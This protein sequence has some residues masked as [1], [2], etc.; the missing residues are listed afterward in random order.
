MPRLICSINEC[1]TPA[2]H[3]NTLCGKHGGVN[4]SDRCKID[5]CNKYVV[6]DGACVKH[7]AKV[8]RCKHEGCTKQAQNNSL[9][10]KHGAERPTC[11]VE[12]CT[13]YIIKSGVCVKHGAK[14]PRCNVEGCNSNRQGGGVCVKHGGT[15]NDIS[16]KCTLC[17]LYRADRKE[18]PTKNEK[19]RLCMNC[20][21]YTFPNEKIPSRYKKKQHYLHDTLKEKYGED[22]FEYD[23]KIDGGC[24]RKI[25]DWFCDRGTHSVLIECDENSH[26]YQSDICENKRMMMLFGDL[27]NRPIVVI[28][29][30]PDTYKT[31]GGT[32]R[33][34]FNFSKTNTLLLNTTEFKRRFESLVK[35]IDE[36]TSTSYVPDKE[37]TMYKL[38]YN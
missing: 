29:F 28:R 20:F 33:G 17:K 7:G 16:H 14:R 35:T 8:N 19:I 22:Y 34:C 31:D 27:A 32:V 12:G 4:S 9:C 6:K 21:A 38:F 13:N 18:H 37:V 26:R 2:R 5:G 11:K 23:K 1:L 10:F 24:S 36:V 25:P 15:Q 3:G 30:N